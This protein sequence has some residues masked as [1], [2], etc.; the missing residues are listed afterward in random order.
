[1]TPNVWLGHPWL[2]MT[3]R[4]RERVHGSEQLRRMGSSV[5]YAGRMDFFPKYF[6]GSL[7]IEQSY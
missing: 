4:K 1:M 7:G 3:D 5:G 6:A 2:S